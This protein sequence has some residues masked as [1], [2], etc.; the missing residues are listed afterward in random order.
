MNMDVRYVSR[1]SFTPGWHDPHTGDHEPAEDDYR[2]ELYADYRLVACIGGD[3]DQGFEDVVDFLAT[4]Y[5]VQFHFGENDRYPYREDT[6]PFAADQK[7]V[8]AYVFEGVGVYDQGVLAYSDTGENHAEYIRVV[9][10]LL[11]IPHVRPEERVAVTGSSEQ[12]APVSVPATSKPLTHD[13]T[14]GFEFVR[15]SL[16]GEPTFAVNFD[17]LQKH[18]ERGYIIFEFLLCDERQAVTPHTSHPKRYWHKNS[19]K[20]LALFEV[21]RALDAT[22]Y[23]VNYAKAGTAHADEVTVIE[24]HDVGA[25]GILDEEITR[26]TRE[27]F[28]RWFRRLNAECA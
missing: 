16:R 5:P 2:G 22:L 19:R 10:E 17:R 18:P 25:D 4:H 13:D 20:F 27:G 23:L 11:G 21:A 24:V 6:V 9:L 12:A 26:F 8:Q 1:G 28:S 3:D 14:S 15:E 7:R